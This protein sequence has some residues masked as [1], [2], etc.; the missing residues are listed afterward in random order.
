MKLSE[1]W[2]T[3]VEKHNDGGEEQYKFWQ[4]YC[5]SEKNIYRDILADQNNQI[6]VVP[7]DLAE[8]YNMPISWIG[9]FL[10]GIEESLDNQM[11][12]H[13]NIA[14]DTSVTLD[15]NFEKLYKNMLAVPADWLYNLQEW[16]GIFSIE[17]RE[18]FTKEYKQSKTYVRE[19]K[20]GRNDPCPCGS[21][22]KYKKC[23]GK[24]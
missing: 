9:G 18:R 10:E 23:C 24:N 21:G 22:K 20:V 12:D 6:T 15:I 3:E 1:L 8:R 17:D 7:K 14:E 11:A 19:N 5:D 4:D 16:D 2:K 13:E